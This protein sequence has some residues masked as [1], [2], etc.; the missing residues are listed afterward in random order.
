MKML[1]GKRVHA[2]FWREKKGRSVKHTDMQN[3]GVIRVIFPG[4]PH[5][6]AIGIV[7]V[8]DLRPDVDRD[9]IIVKLKPSDSGGH[10]E[11]FDTR[12]FFSWAIVRRP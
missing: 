12:G 1:N 7:E 11:S 5:D 8:P 2:V 6:G 3:R 4:V 9:T 10:V